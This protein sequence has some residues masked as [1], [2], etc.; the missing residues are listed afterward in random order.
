MTDNQSE[1]D[2]QKGTEITSL[3][4]ITKPRAIDATKES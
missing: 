1:A 4:Q 3:Q 2:Q